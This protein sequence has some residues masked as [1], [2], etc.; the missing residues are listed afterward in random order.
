[1]LRDRP[2]R[3]DE[4]QAEALAVRVLGFIAGDAEELGRFLA[5]TGI[6]P[7][8]IRAAAGD[9][10]FLVGLLEYLMSDKSLLIAFSAREKIRPTTIAAARHVL[11]AALPDDAPVPFED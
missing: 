3:M 11:D 4:A 7:E 8:S 10:A 2:R 5:L 6:G 9:P 1:M